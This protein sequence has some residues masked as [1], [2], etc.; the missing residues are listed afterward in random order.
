M[1]QGGMETTDMQQKKRRMTNKWMNEDGWAP[2]E[3]N[4]TTLGGKVVSR[5]CNYH[6][7]ASNLLMERTQ[8]QGC[9]YKKFMTHK[10]WMIR[11]LD[12]RVRCVTRESGVRACRH[13]L[14]YWTWLIYLR[15]SIWWR[16]I[17][18]IYIL[19]MF[20]AYRWCVK[21]LKH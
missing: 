4:F 19:V 21:S 10:K 9:R 6:C 8:P 16:D 3:A 7:A 13:D 17:I 11:Y 5:V 18:R 12:V 1:I 2:V 14:I 20:V 15:Y